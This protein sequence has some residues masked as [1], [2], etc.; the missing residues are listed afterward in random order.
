MKR[1]NSLLGLAT[2]ALLLR[3]LAP[4]LS[5]SAS[6]EKAQVF[7]TAGTAQEL[8]LAKGWV[9]S[10]SFSWEGVP[11]IMRTPGFSAFLLPGAAMR[12]PE[13]VSV[14]L[15]ALLGTATVLLLYRLAWLVTGRQAPAL[16]AALLLAVEPLSILLVAQVRPQPLFTFLLVLHLTLLST[17]LRGGGLRPLLWGAVTASG[18]AFV[19]PAAL[20]LPW[21]GFLLLLIRLPARRPR[22]RGLIHAFAFLLLAVGLTGLWRTRNQVVVNY[23]GFSARTAQ[24]LYLDLG[25][26]VLALRDGADAAAERATLAQNLEKKFP[27]DT[28]ENRARTQGR[29]FRFERTEGLRLLGENPA[30]LAPVLARE[31]LA[32][33]TG[34]VSPFYWGVSPGLDALAHPALSASSPFGGAFRAALDEVRA[35][36]PVA[37]PLSLLLEGLAG[38]LLLLALIGLLRGKDL[39][40]SARLAFLV[41]VV[42]FLVFSGGAGAP[43]LARHAVMPVICL[44]A[45]EGLCSLARTRETAAPIPV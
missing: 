30:L 37:F 34:P 20:C 25:S 35:A 5:F 45:A 4:V 11:E 28:P 16:L 31:V 1:A 2:L 29:R 8:Q 7:R 9:R 22:G 33:L 36:D 38:A 10:G 19:D 44:L 23:P 13:T 3:L 42:V 14:V 39:P 40:V 26:K 27:A 21:L 18:C 6:E 41:F 12:N 32:A 15:Q 17:F 43:V 24:R